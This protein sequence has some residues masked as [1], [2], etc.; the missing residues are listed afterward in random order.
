MSKD[1]F[2]SYTTSNATSYE[3]SNI[4]FY[5]VVSNNLELTIVVDP[6]ETKA[7]LST[8]VVKKHVFLLF[9]LLF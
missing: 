1:S 8:S 5:T 7:S 3:V 9:C 2:T 6:L 4:E